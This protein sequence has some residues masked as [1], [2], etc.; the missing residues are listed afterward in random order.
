[1]AIDFQYQFVKII[2]FKFHLFTH[3]ASLD[4]ARIIAYHGDMVIFTMLYYWQKN[5]KPSMVYKR[6]LNG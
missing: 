5:Y 6:N 2:S 4:F 3:V 1:M